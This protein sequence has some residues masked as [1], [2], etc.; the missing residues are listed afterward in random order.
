MSDFGR[1]RQHTSN[2]M[3]LLCILGEY[4]RVLTKVLAELLE[5]QITWIAQPSY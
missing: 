1:E 5:Y 3:E 4:S 2:V